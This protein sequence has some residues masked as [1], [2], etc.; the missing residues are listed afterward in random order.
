MISDGDDECPYRWKGNRLYKWKVSEERQI[1]D[2]GEESK[3]T[4]QEGKSVDGEDDVRYSDCYC[5]SVQVAFHDGRIFFSNFACQVQTVISDDLLEVKVCVR[6]TNGH[7]KC[8]HHEHDLYLGCEKCD[9]DATAAHQCSH[10]SS[11]PAETLIAKTTRPTQPPATL[12]ILKINPIA[13]KE[14]TIYNDINNQLCT[15]N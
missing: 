7:V 14:L 2:I 15:N 10:M 12:K 13:A 11:Y 3:R 9:R 1:G 8:L 4:S 6:D 5:G